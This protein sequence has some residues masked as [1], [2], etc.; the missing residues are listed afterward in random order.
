MD[1][2]NYMFLQTLI[3][4]NTDDPLGVVTEFQDNFPNPPIAATC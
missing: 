4:Y 2:D 3:L 1:V